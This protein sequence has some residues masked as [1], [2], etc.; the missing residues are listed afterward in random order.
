MG[1]STHM[2]GTPKNPTYTIH[3]FM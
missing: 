2:I 1:S 3:I